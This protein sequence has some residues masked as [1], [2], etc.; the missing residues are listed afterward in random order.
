MVSLG[1]AKYIGVIEEILIHG[2]GASKKR[3]IFKKSGKFEHMIKS[4][5]EQFY[6]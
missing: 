4:M 2:T 5:K 1:S 3:N 6:Q